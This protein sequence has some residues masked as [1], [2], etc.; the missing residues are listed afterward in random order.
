[1][2]IEKFTPQSREALFNAKT[3]AESANN[4]ELHP[5]H[6]LAAL[7]DDPDNLVNSILGKLGVNKELFRGKTASALAELPRLANPAPGEISLSREFNAVL[8]GA[9]K[10]AAEMG[11]EYVS[12]EH[13]LLALASGSG[14]TAGLLN[15]SGITPESI[16][17]CLQTLRG[18]ARYTAPRG[19]PPV[20][21]PRWHCRINLIRSSAGTMRSAG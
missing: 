2:N 1:M 19:S 17:N 20:I 5:L 8:N 14:K 13:L 10:K 15:D 9:M 7:L 18:F 12:V 6:L 16:M 3:D 21:L 11:D 4:P